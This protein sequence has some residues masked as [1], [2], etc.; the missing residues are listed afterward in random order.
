MC[1]KAKRRQSCFDVVKSMFA[2]QCLLDLKLYKGTFLCADDVE[3]QFSCPF[4]VSLFEWV[5]ADVEYRVCGR[6]RSDVLWYDL[7]ALGVVSSEGLP[8]EFL[9]PAAG[10]DVVVVPVHVGLLRVL[11][12]VGDVLRCVATLKHGVGSRGLLRSLP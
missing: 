3:V 1:E 9:V 10:I 4:W 5:Y 6:V 7:P 12:Q 8:G 11:P 2:S